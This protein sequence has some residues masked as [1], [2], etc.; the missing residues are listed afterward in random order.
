MK[1]TDIKIPVIK[2]E[3]P[4]QELRRIR[5]AIAE[6]FDYDGRAIAEYIRAVPLLPGQ[7]WYEPPEGK[8]KGEKAKVKNPVSA[9]GKTTKPA[10]KLT[11]RKAPTHA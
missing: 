4:L 11:R 5:D 8:S 2:D 3:D 10:S 1:K 7:K 6:K 9:R